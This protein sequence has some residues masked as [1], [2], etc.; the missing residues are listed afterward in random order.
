[1]NESGAGRVIVGI[2]GSATNDGGVGLA[3]ALG[4]RFLDSAGRE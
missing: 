1:L 3:A 4:Y 2:G